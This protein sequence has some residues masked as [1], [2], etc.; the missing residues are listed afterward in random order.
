MKYQPYTLKLLILFFLFSVP[1]HSADLELSVD[2]IPNYGFV[3]SDELDDTMKIEHKGT[4][5][6]YSK[7]LS[8]FSQGGKW[9]LLIWANPM[10]SGDGK[11]KLEQALVNYK[12]YGG[13]Q[14]AIPDQ[15]S[16]IWLPLP[17]TPTL[18]YQ[19]TEGQT[20]FDFFIYVTPRTTQMQKTY[21]TEV[22]FRLV[23]L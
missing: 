1:L 18:I 15:N 7:S 11:D 5:C 3:Q 8:V 23:S 4:N 20:D 17:Y 16:N 14:I 2:I 12:I 22:T 13:N 19:S 9:G 10:V 6:R 21:K